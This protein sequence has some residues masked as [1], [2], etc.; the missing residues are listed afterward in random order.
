M[1]NRLFVGNLSF[2]INDSDLQQ[3]FQP[4]GTVKE[5]KLMLDRD[6]GRSRGFAFIEM[7]SESDAQRAIEALHGASLD[8]RPLRVSEAEDRRSS[9]SGPPSGGNDRSN[10]YGRKPSR[11]DRY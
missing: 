2:Q 1:G 8:G 3:A 4:Y 9:F 7:M 11:G 6:T 5:V 10:G